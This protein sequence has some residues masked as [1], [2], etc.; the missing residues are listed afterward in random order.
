[1]EAILAL[2]GGDENQMPKFLDASQ[3]E[4]PLMGAEEGGVGEDVDV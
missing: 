2:I 3:T 4:L 1:M